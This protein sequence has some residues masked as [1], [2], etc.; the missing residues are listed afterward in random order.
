LPPFGGRMIF[1]PSQRMRNMAGFGLVPDPPKEGVTTRK[2]RTPSKKIEI[3]NEAR[4]FQRTFLEGGLPWPYPFKD[5]ELLIITLSLQSAH[6]YGRAVDRLMAHTDRKDDRFYLV[7]HLRDRLILEGGVRQL[8]AD[9]LVRQEQR[10]ERLPDYGEKGWRGLAFNWRG[11]RAKIEWYRRALDGWG[12]SRRVVDEV[13]GMLN[14][15]T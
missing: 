15:E 11:R 2:Y 12:A 4:E 9:Y 8:A 7:R 13:W 1:L 5:Q 10:L 6:E 3:T 14:K